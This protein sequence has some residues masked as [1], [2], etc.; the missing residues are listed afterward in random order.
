VSP[1]RRRGPDSPRFE[2]KTDSTWDFY[3]AGDNRPA[4]GNGKAAIRSSTQ[5]SSSSSSP[6][7]S[8]IAPFLDELTKIVERLEAA[9]VKIESQANEVRVPRLPEIPRYNRP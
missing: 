9:V 4:T 1:V 6:S 5:A 2:V 7:A 3:V 8:A